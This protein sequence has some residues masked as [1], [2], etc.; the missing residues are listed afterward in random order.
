MLFWVLL[1]NYDSTS[2][3]PPSP[4]PPS[5]ILFKSNTPH[6]GQV[7][8]KRLHKIAHRHAP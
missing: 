6:L 1:Y 4:F 2:P 7:A 8:R 5:L 3:S